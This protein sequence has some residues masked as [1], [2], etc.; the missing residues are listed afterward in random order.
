MSDLRPLFRAM[1]LP[2]LDGDTPKINESEAIKMI[3]HAIDNGL[4]Y[5]DTAYP[6]PGGNTER[7]VA[8]AP[9]DG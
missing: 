6:Y 5:V 4:H 8:N 3:H 1:R 9:K 2:I 7:L